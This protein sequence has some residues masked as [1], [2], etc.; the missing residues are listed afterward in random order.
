VLIVFNDNSEKTN[1]IYIRLIKVCTDI[2][3][4]PAL[5]KFL[6]L[7]LI[8]YSHSGITQNKANTEWLVVSS[9]ITFKIKNAG[10]VVNGS[11]IGLNAKINFDAS[12]NVGN[13]IQAS[14]DAKSIDTDNSTRNGHLKKEEY[15]NVEKYPK[16]SLI[17]TFFGK[18][19]DGFRGYFN[20]TIKDKT[21]QVAIPFTYIEKT[22]K[23]VFKGSF[24]INRLDFGVGQSSI[25]L[26]D[27]VTVNI[28]VNVQKR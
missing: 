23:A 8:L 19:K 22:G 14:V 9:S 7:F 11:F 17:S 6:F 20:L 25:I 4:P 26:S 16:I 2:H 12:K 27:N 18:D 13:F 5:N 3:I 1:L 21:K 28:E 15:F 10:I 24:T